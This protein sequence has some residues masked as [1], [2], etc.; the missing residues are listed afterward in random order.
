MSYYDSSYFNNPTVTTVTS[1]ITGQ[2]IWTIIAIVISI[3]GGIALYFTIFSKKNDEKYKGVMAV[4]YNLVHFKYFV[5]DD[6]F[7]ILYIISVL[8]ITLYSFSFIGKW[9]FLV[10]LV[11]GNLLLRI[12]YEFMMLFMELCHNVRNISNKTK[13]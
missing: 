8:F 1:N 9:Q 4:L 3:V 2:L 11:G 7:R 6:I 12:S 5:I 10:I 13:K